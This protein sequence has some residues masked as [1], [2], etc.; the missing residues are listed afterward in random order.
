ML[1]PKFS[2][3]LKLGVISIQVLQIVEDSYALDKYLRPV[4]QTLK[5]SKDLC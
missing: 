1:G 3:S 2:T 5:H 4:T